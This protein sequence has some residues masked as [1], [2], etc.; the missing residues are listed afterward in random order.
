MIYNEVRPHT[1][2]G[3]VGQKNIVTSIRRQSAMGKF[4]GLYIFEGQYG[5]GKTT[6]ARILALAA[7]CEHKDENG[8]PCLECE[9]CKA[10]LSGNS[11]DYMEIDAASK[12]GV[13]DIR[14]VIEDTTYQ[15][16]F[17]KTKVYIIDE[18]HM[19]SKAA[20]NSFLKTLEEPPA[21]CLFILCTTDKKAIPATV[22]SRAA[23]YTFAQISVA[24]ICMGLKETA[25]KYQ[26]DVNEDALSVIAKASNGAMR[27]ALSLLEQSASYGEQVTTELVRSMLGIS[28]T[29]DIFT[30]VGAIATGNTVEAIHVLES[31]A[32]AGKSMNYL[33]DDTLEVL[34]DAI[35]YSASN[36]MELIANAEDYKNSIKELVKNASN[37]EL[38]FI[39]NSIMELRSRLAKDMSLVPV[40]AGVV[41]MT[42]KSQAINE[43]VLL[44]KM[45]ELENKIKKLESG[46]VF[47]QV[48][49]E[50]VF[51]ESVVAESSDTD[52]SD[53]K[54]H[55]EI[56]ESEEQCEQVEVKPNEETL[57]PVT[58]N[59][60]E[61]VDV[62]Q[63]TMDVFNF[64]F[65]YFTKA[66]SSMEKKQELEEKKEIEFSTH[67][68][69]VI[70]Q[71]E[72]ICGAEPAF[73]SA[74]DMGCIMSEQHGK[75]IYT[76]PLKP[77]YDVVR[78]YFDAY[79]LDAM[80]LFDVN[81][82]LD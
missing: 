60:E 62:E 63:S 56:S 42:Q 76:T 41:Q 73:Q 47:Q 48:N 52:Y 37:Q 11:A 27:N 22:R 80:V 59:E 58:K 6:M 32:E 43:N 23:M 21:Y 51:S 70:S 75:L 79:N 69:E 74:I 53:E 20:F 24:D 3:M 66:S 77:V 39:S 40:I 64:S 65:D 18:V 4:M 30:L 14:G 49:T 72:V 67:S 17:L 8:N 45:Q 38:C 50:P 13:D 29:G 54:E 31:L 5:S 78:S 61:I 34:T 15:P 28:R 10:I 19:L 46:V 9:H 26:I 2:D 25:S 81:T 16:S 7:N 71:I 36:D 12:N 55:I 1:F 35:V 57:A 68:K 44:L 33:L 82:I